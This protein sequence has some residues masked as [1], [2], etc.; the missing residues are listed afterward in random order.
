MITSIVGRLIK[1]PEVNERVNIPDKT[2]MNFTVVQSIRRGQSKRISVFYNLS[3][4]VS[5][6]NQLN[7]IQSFDKGTILNFSSPRINFVKQNEPTQGQYGEEVTINIYADVQNF[8]I[9]SG[10]GAEGGGG[11]GGFGQSSGGFGGGGGQQRRPAPSRGN[12]SGHDPGPSDFDD[13]FAE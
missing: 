11:G 10:G 7:L 3:M 1:R 13:P 12:D 6:E 5:T 8:E 4:V 9:L 2:V